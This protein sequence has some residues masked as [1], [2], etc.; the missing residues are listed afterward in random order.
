MFFGFS[1]VVKLPSMYSRRNPDPTQKKLVKVLTEQVAKIALGHL[2][3]E[4]SGGL[5]AVC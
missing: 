2:Q 4:V 1:A 5:V 3:P